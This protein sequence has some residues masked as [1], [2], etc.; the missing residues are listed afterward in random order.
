MKS[1]VVFSKRALPS[2]F[3]GQIW[4]IL[5]A[6]IILEVFGTPW[7]LEDEYLTSDPG[8]FHSQRPNFWKENCPSVMIT[9]IKP[10]F[11]KHEI[12]GFHI[13]VSNILCS[14]FPFLHPPLLSSPTPFSLK[15]SYS[16]P[17]FRV[18]HPLPQCP[19]PHSSPFPIS[20]LQ[21]ILQVK[22]TN[23][24]IWSWH[25]Y[26]RKNAQHLSFWICIPLVSIIS[27]VPSIH[28]PTNFII[29]FFF[30]AQ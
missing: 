2:H 20:C 1:F 18:C 8:L 28:L 5:T 21:L 16:S 3:D 30:I 23:V 4:A 13:S 9:P 10:Y 11:R 15:P 26:L 22:H 14:V 7:P 6:R 25:L 24:R 17:P 27:L 19:P 12:V 29:L